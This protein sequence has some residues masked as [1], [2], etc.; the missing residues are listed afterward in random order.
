MTA[1]AV[2][3]ESRMA[4]ITNTQQIGEVRKPRLPEKAYSG[5]PTFKST[6]YRLLIF[7]CNSDTIGTT[8]IRK[9]GGFVVSIRCFGREFVLRVCQKFIDCS[10]PGFNPFSGIQFPF[11]FECLMSSWKVSVSPIWMSTPNRCTL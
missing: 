7:I 4:T 3:S 10:I 1:T 8:V 9:C 11:D 6:T 2:I 5:F